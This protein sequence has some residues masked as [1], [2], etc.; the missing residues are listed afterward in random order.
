[1]RNDDWS[2][3][4][5]VLPAGPFGPDGTRAYDLAHPLEPGMPR[6]PNHPP[7][8]FTLT[9]QH[10][11]VVYEGGVS[12]AAELIT[13]GGHVGTHVDALGH[14]S[15]DGLVHGGRSIVEDQSYAF[16]LGVGSVEEVP[17]LLAP[18]HLVDAVRLFGRPLEPGDAVGAEHLERW[19]TDRGEPQAGSIVLVR[20]GWSRHW[21]DFRTFHG[22]E[23]GLPGVDVSGATWLAERGIVASGSDTLVYEQT[24][25]GAARLPVHVDFLVDRGIY[26]LEALNLDALARDEVDEFFFLAL[27]LRVRGGTGSPLRPVAMVSADRV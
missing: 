18:G 23:T 10:G 19:F 26:I 8:A 7:Y 21:R 6:H 11:E 20:T 25:P 2:G 15:R 4:Y 5:A 24:S 3:N 13:T 16:G 14:V 9:K 1:M 22:I 12:A 27:P 17:P